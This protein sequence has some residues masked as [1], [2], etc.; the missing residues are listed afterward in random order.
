MCHG[1]F[2]ILIFAICMQLFE[3]YIVSTCIFAIQALR[4]YKHNFN[5]FDKANENLT[6]LEIFYV[7][8]WIYQKKIAS[9]REPSWNVNPGIRTI[10]KLHVHVWSIKF[11]WYLSQYTVRGKQLPLTLIPKVKI[12]KLFECKMKNKSYAIILINYVANFEF[13]LIKIF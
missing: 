1:N 4:A 12:Y 13:H 9:Y 5:S 11:H 10:L 7:I 3:I 6:I 8:N 2:D